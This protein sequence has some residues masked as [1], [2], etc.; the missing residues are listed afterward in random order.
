MTIADLLKECEK[1]EKANAA[2]G[3]HSRPAFIIRINRNCKGQR[4]KVMPG[5]F[6]RLVHRGNGVCVGVLYCAEVRHAI[7]QLSIAAPDQVDAIT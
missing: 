2:L 1:V 6:A 4:A 5:L 3:S 7:A